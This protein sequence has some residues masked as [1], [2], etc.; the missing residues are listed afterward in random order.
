M[1]QKRDAVVLPLLSKFKPDS[2]RGVPGFF[3]IAQTRSGQW[4][5]IDPF[6]QPFF[7]KGVACVS[8]SGR[9]NGRSLS[10]SQYRQMVEALY[11]ESSD[12]FVRSVVQ[13]LRSWRF[14]T[15]AGGVA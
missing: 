14:N 1:A 6:D 4:W 8:R 2:F 11:G 9:P 15:L 10:P 7:S 3:R 5:F 12:G 13:R